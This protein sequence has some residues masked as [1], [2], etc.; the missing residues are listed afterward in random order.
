LNQRNCHAL[1]FI[2]L[3]VAINLVA[4]QKNNSAIA[5][6]DAGTFSILVSGHRVATE[7]FHI[8]QV[9]G[10]ATIYSN[11]QYSDA[12]NKAEQ[13][14]VMELGRNGQLKRYTWKEV[15]PSKSM[16][17]VEPE[18]QNFL[19]LKYT[20]NGEDI[21]KAKDA[22]R[23]LSPNTVILDD[24][25]FVHIEVLAWRHMASICKLDEK[26]MNQCKGD[27]QQYPV[28]VPHQQFSA[29][30]TIQLTGKSKFKWK[31]IDRNCKTLKLVTESGEWTIWLL[32][33]QKDNMK[34]L[35]VTT[36]EGLE[37]LRD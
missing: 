16:I 4:A 27:A 13:T 5:P 14:S 28:L 15:T 23:P 10:S 32:E 3:L 26:G 2:T 36:P 8:D 6:V 17:V 34:M 18:D 35:R 24:N 1:L 33:D 30:V 19:S 7:I 20:E 37:V 29:I 22:S 31:G 25:I 9:P 11:L 21:T 12:N